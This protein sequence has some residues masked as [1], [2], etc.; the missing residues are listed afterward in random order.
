MKSKRNLALVLAELVIILLLTAAAFIWGKRTALTERG[1]EACGGEYLLLL[2]PFMYYTG[3][4]VVLQWIEFR[5]EG[6][7]NADV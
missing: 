4:R 1:Y 6:Q 2:L 3:K 5:K 7:Q